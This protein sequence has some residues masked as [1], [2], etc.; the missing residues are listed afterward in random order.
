MVDIDNMK[1]LENYRKAFNE[2][3][4]ERSEGQ[5]NHSKESTV[6]GPLNMA[7]T[8]VDDYFREL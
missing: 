2:V 3:W 4:K 5:P 8:L 6:K 1:R 7:D